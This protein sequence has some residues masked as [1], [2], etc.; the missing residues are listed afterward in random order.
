MSRIRGRDTKP[1]LVV[2]S[3]LH[4]LGFRFRVHSDALPGRPDIVLSRHCAAVFVHGC[5][6]HRHPGC[7]YAYT[8]KSNVSFW[9]DKF[10][11]N[12]VRDSRNCRELQR[13]GWRVL[14][15]WECQTVDRN[16]LARRLA[17]RFEL[18]NCG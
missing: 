18:L 17:A 9:K 11:R 13:L 10:E 15:V 1:E 12:I 6:W 16:A 2:R 4:R 5:F 3:V 8:P 7:R 14:I